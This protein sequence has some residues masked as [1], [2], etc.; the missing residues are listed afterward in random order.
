MG[1]S[2]YVMIAIGQES[3]LGLFGVV[4]RLSLVALFVYAIIK[5]LADPAQL[6][7]PFEHGLGMSPSLAGA[8]FVVTVLAL[9]ACIMLLLLRRGGG[10]FAVSGVFFLVGMVYSLYLSQHQYQGSCGCGVGITKGA[11]NE[12][13]VHAYQNAACAVSCFFIGIRA[14][15]LGKDVSYE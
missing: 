5:K 12:L 14:R 9:M 10:G 13:V 8:M 7:N 11:E 2:T 15:M 4:L 3:R 1:C 6:L